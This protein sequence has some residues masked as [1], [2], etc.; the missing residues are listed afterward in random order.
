MVDS[1]TPVI[2]NCVAPFGVFGAINPNRIP[3]AA[4]VFVIEKAFEPEMFDVVHDVIN[5]GV[6]HVIGDAP[7]PAEVRSCPVVP[8]EVGRVKLYPVKAVA[9]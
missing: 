6:V 8:A 5:D 9:G 2:A 4:P 3:P 7:P 1:A